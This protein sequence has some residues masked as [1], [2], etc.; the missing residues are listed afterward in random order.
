[1]VEQ[2]QADL[3]K[4]RIKREEIE[5]PSRKEGKRPASF[6]YLGGVIVL[7]VAAFFFYKTALT[8]VPEV[9]TTTPALISPNQMSS[10][11]TAS[12]YVVAQR[13][14]SIASKATGRLVYLGFDAGDQVTK[15]EIIGRIESTDVEAALEQAKASLEV[16]NADLV[17]AQHGLE[18]AKSLFEQKLNSQA[19]LDAA[20]ATYDRTV[21]N[22]ALQKAGVQAAEV[23][24]ENTIIRAPFTG[25]ILEKNADFGE[26]VAPFAAGASSRVAIVT[27]ADMSSLEVEADVSETNFQKVSINQPCE[28]T[29]DSYPEHRYRGFVAKIVPTADRAKGTVLTKVKF[30]D[31]DSHVL[32][33]MAAKVHFLETGKEINTNSEMKLAVAQSAVVTR[34]GKKVVYVVRDYQLHETPIETGELMGSQVEIKSGVTTNDKVVTNPGDDLHDGMKIKLKE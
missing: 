23:Q 12:G 16:G 9:E 3:S 29:L 27:I 15:G 26:V 4:L 1:M 11:M 30:V 7:L 18:R 6:L 21:A 20:Q 25:T 33:E 19:D 32:P 31:R 13:K 34:N 24:V 28:I 14:A 22:I 5:A 17:S 10:L 8:P 2:Q